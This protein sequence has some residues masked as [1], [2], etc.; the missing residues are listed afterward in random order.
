[1]RRVVTVSLAILTLLFL[2]FSATIL[3]AQGNRDRV[4]S[5][6]TRNLDAGSDFGFVINAANDPNPTPYELL[7]AISNTFGEMIGSNIPLRAQGIATEVAAYHPDLIAL[8]EVTTLRVGPFQQPA[9]TVIVD[10]L[11]SLVTELGKQGLH[12]KVVAVQ[13]NAA[14]DLPAL[15]ATGAL[16]TAGFTDYDAVLARTDLQISQ[17]QIS[18]VAMDHFSNILPFTVGDQTIP[19]LRGWISMQVQIRGKNYKFVTTHLETFSAYFQNRQ[20]EE[21][22]AGPLNSNLPVILAGDLNSD[23]YQPNLNIGPAIV[24]LEAAGFQD[25]WFTLHP[26]D[27]GLTWPLFAEDPAGPATPFQRIDLVLT[28]GAGIQNKAVVQTGLS[29]FNGVWSS[30]HAGI[31]GQFVILP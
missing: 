1:M 8:Q 29:P 31:F 12:Y 2:L 16:I 18:N 30:D 9:N 3:P 26:Q 21:L 23:A 15:D 19:F 24:D 25:V 7:F 27:A 6:M 5:V 11:Q 13:T 22:L 20:T 10:G 28:A 4:V 17:M 14:V